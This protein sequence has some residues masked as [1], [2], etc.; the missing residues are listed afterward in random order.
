MDI[1][2]I[3]Q[4]RINRKSRLGR[5][6]VIF[7]DS[8]LECAEAAKV[9]VNNSTLPFTNLLERSTVI[10]MATSIEVYYKDV[11]D[12]IFRICTPDFFQPAL[13]KIHDTKYDI[14]DL[15]ELYKSQVNPLELISAKQSFQNKDAIESVFSKFLGCSFWKAVQNTKV[16]VKDKP[17]KVYTFSWEDINA[18]DALFS[19][20]HE[21]VHN[22]SK[23]PFFSKQVVD[24]IVRSAWL[25]FGSDIVLMEMISAHRD[26]SIDK[27]MVR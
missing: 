6:F 22:P 3:I 16:R 26:P 20:R 24:D 1:N 21:L 5:P 12:I 15:L 25:V 2:K 23:H 4:S 18:L 19:L 7:C 9:L 17:E 14:I 10:T 11:L 13:K 8:F 27:E